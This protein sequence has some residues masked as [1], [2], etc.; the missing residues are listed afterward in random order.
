MKK[1]VL[2]T[3]VLVFCLSFMA[4][5]DKKDEGPVDEL[6]GT[7]SG[8]DDSSEKVSWYFD[9]KGSCHLTTPILNKS[10]GKYTIDGD[11]LEIKLDL[12]S[13]PIK[14][15]FAT[16]GIGLNIEAVNA[17]NPSYYLSKE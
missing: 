14:H 9:G 4:A 7:W 6:A 2:F 1:L 16:L 15:T 3:L 13:E 8:N 5:C 10:P 11:T 12:W 17:W